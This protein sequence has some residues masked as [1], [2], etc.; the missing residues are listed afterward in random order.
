M[1]WAQ[2]APQCTTST[3]NK[4]MQ[5][6]IGRRSRKVGFE[7]EEADPF[8]GHDHGA[9][10]LITDSHHL[11][12]AAPVDQVILGDLPASALLRLAIIRACPDRCIQSE[13]S[14]LFSSTHMEATSPFVLWNDGSDTAFCKGVCLLPPDF[15]PAKYLQMYVLRP[16]SRAFRCTK[17]TDVRLFAVQILFRTQSCS[18]QSSTYPIPVALIC[19]RNHEQ[20]KDPSVVFQILH[21][22]RSSRS[23][24]CPDQDLPV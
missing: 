6:P 8:R 13:V 21:L 5:G 4:K 19:D 18:T 14:T 17:C 15:I 9:L 2:I 3:E 16:R 11:A 24:A 20:C 7:R 12:A 22:K 1:V 23:N 10:G